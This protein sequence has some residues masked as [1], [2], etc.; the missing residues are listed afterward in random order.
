MQSLRIWWVGPNLLPA[1]GIK[2][3][4]LVPAVIAAL[5]LARL[6]GITVT[7]VAAWLPY[8]AALTSTIPHTTGELIVQLVTA[9]GASCIFRLVWMSRR[10]GQPRWIDTTGRT[11]QNT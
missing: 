11:Q 8:G 2:W 9:L 1:R 4:G 3:L 10:P 5:D 6:A 7:W